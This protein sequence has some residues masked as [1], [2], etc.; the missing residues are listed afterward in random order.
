MYVLLLEIYNVVLYRM[1]KR[2]SKNQWGH[3][4]A[5][6]PAWLCH[7]LQK[8]S[9]YTIMFWL[10]CLSSSHTYPKPNPIQVCGEGCVY[11]AL[12]R[13]ATGFLHITSICNTFLCQFANVSELFNVTTAFPNCIS[14]TGCYSPIS[15]PPACG[16]LVLRLEDCFR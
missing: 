15:N 14:C 9:G 7:C 13:P 6:E 12:K 3:L 11:I 2:N 4:H 10:K 8:Q 1:D 16:L 5:E